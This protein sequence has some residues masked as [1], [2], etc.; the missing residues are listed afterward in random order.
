MKKINLPLVQKVKMAYKKKQYKF[1]FF[2]LEPD[3][4]I[5]LTNVINAHQFLYRLAQKKSFDDFQT[6]SIEE[7]KF[8]YEK[9]YKIFWYLHVTTKTYFFSFSVTNYTEPLF[10]GTNFL[11]QL[12]RFQYQKKVIKTLSL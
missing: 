4:K 1:S 10:V 8:L 6:F 3:I 11:N 12:T 9:L 2:L 7:K 5:S